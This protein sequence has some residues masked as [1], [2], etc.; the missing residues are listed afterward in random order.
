MGPVVLA[1][2]VAQERP[3]GSRPL[4]AASTV[5]RARGRRSRRPD[6]GRHAASSTKA[7][8]R[9]E[10]STSARTK[11]SRTRR[12]RPRR[13]AAHGAATDRA[14]SRLAR[15]QNPPGRPRPF[16]FPR[17]ARVAPG[18]QARVGAILAIAPS[19]KSGALPRRS[20]SMSPLR[21]S[22][23]PFRRA[24]SGR[25]PRR[26]EASRRLPESFSRTLAQASVVVGRATWTSETAS[27][28]R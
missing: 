5:G 19:S 20:I 28:G 2:G 10:S 13:P 17:H 3:P 26:I 21:P 24:R 1:R 15:R 11:T 18:S 8:R 16:R 9:S 4:A 22:Q 27:L 23:G 6:R 7:F 12:N 25:A 14:G